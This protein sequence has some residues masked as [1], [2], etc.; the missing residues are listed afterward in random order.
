MKIRMGR[1]ISAETHR[2]RL[3][4]SSGRRSKQSPLAAGAVLHHQQRQAAD[5]KA[6]AQHGAQQPG[7]Q[8]VHELIV[9]HQLSQHRQHHGQDGEDRPDDERATAPLAMRA[10]RRARSAGRARVA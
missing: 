9:L 10:R 5:R 4:A 8:Q 2:V 6:P 1:N 7:G 3:M